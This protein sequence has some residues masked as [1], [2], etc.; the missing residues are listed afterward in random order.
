MVLLCAKYTLHR[1]EN[2]GTAPEEW[3]RGVCVCL[4]VVKRKKKK[5]IIVSASGALKELE[6]VDGW[7]Q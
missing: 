3:R 4:R 6:V 7:A 2:T 1:Q 5:R